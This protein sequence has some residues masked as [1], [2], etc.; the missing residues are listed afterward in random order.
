MNIQQ[1]QQLFIKRIKE[2]LEDDETNQNLEIFL[3]RSFLSPPLNNCLLNMDLSIIEF[4]IPFMLTCIES[5]FKTTKQNNS[6]VYQ[7]NRFQQ[8]IEIDET[9]LHMRAKLLHK[10]LT[11]Q[12]SILSPFDDYHYLNFLF[13]LIQL[14]YQKYCFNLNQIEKVLYIL[15]FEEV[16]PQYIANHWTYARNPNGQSADIKDRLDV[17]RHCILFKYN[18]NYYVDPNDC[19]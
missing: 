6:N 19:Y 3:N 7:T 1:Q 18:L 9:Q 10:L 8:K 14:L 11:N 17:I 5:T 15:Q 16:I 13:K 12:D 4:C 2:M